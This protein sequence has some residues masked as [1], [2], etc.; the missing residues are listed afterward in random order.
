MVNYSDC[1]HKKNPMIVG[2][3]K[4][5]YTLISENILDRFVLTVVG[6]TLAVLSIHSLNA[7]D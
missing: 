1:R 7:L 5:E 4:Y 2:E 3:T 6:C